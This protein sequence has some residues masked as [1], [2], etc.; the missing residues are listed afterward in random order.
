MQANNIIDSLA[1]WAKKTPNA[2]AFTFL[3]ANGTSQTLSYANLY[4]RSQKI[5]RQLKQ[6][7]QPNQAVLLCF[8][9][10]LQ[11]VET[12][13]A[14]LIAGVVAIPLYPPRANQKQARISAVLQ[15][16]GAQVILTDTAAH[17]A[18]AKSLADGAPQATILNLQP[19]ASDEQVVEKGAFSDIAFLQYT[20]GSTGAPKGVVVTHNNIVANLDALVEATGAN[21]KDVFVNWLPVFHDLGL[22]NTVLLPVYLGSHSVLMAP[23]QFIREP[24]FW[25]SA[26]DK[27]NG[28]IC[29]GPNFAFDHCVQ[30]LNQSQ[31]AQ[32]NLSSW[33]VAFNAAEPINA[34]T[35][36][37]FSNLC[38][39]ADFDKAAFFPSYGMAEATVFICG[40]FYQQ[41]SVRY[42][43]RQALN[44]GRAISIHIQSSE[45]LAHNTSALLSC[46]RTPSEHAIKI[47]DRESQTEC[48]EGH[49]G[50][51]WFNGP[52]VASGYWQNVQQSQQTF[53]NRLNNSDSQS[54]FLKTGDLGFVLN[55]E[56][57]IVGRCKDLII[58]NG[59]NIY[60]QDIE[61]LV[62]D[63]SDELER[64]S[65]AAFS[66]PQH[67]LQQDNL[68][69]NDLHQ[70]HSHLAVAVEVKRSRLRSF[71]DIAKVETVAKAIRARIAQEL[72]IT[73]EHV[74]FL[75]PGQL[76]KTSSGK[77]QR[78]ATAHLLQQSELNIYARSDLPKLMAQS[79][80]MTGISTN[81]ELS[82][83]Q[84]NLAGSGSTISL[85][86]KKI[87]MRLLSCTLDELDNLDI[88]FTALGG[89]SIKLMTLAAEIEREF[90]VHL[91]ESALYANLTLAQQ[92]LLIQ[93]SSENTH[94]QITAL[95]LQQGKLSA[96]QNRLWFLQQVVPDS[97]MLN[98]SVQLKF[99]G[100]FE[101]SAF[102]TA[103][104]ACLKRHP[105]LT[106]GFCQQGD[107]IVM[108]FAMYPEQDLQK[109]DLTGQ[110]ENQIARQLA[111]LKQ[112][113]ENCHFD[114]LSQ[115]V[116]Q[117]H[118]VNET[119]QQSHFFFCVHHIVADAWSFKIFLE[120][121]S[122]YYHR[123]RNAEVAELAQIDINYLDY[124]V[125]QEKQLSAEK[126]QNL[127]NFWQQTL[128]PMPATLALPFDYSPTKEKSYRGGKVSRTITGLHPQ[129]EAFAKSQNVTVF[130]AYCAVY[131]ILL[132]RISGQLDVVIGTDVIN[133][134][135]ASLQ[136]VF[137]F[138]VNQIALR[139]ELTLDDTMQEVVAKCQN[140]VS[141][142]QV[143]Q[144]LPFEQVVE[145]VDKAGD[146]S[147]SPVFQV[148]FLL[149]PSP[150]KALQLADV[151]IEQQAL[152]V[153]HAQYDLT[154]AVDFELDGSAQ[155]NCH[156]DGALFA[157]ST[158]GQLADSYLHILNQLLVHSDK[159]LSQVEYLTPNQQQ[160]LEQYSTG[161]KVEVTQ[162]F[163]DGLAHFA[164]ETPDKIACIT[165]HHQFSYAEINQR[166]NQLAHLL[167]AV[168]VQNSVVG[169]S[170]AQSDELLVALCAIGKIGATFVPLDPGYPPERLSFMLADSEA[171]FLLGDSET[172][173]VLADDFLGTML[174]LQEFS[175]LLSVQSGENPAV[176]IAAESLAYILY[177][178]GS[179]GQAKGVKV[180]YAA[181][182]NLCNW[183]LDFSKTT[184]DSV[185][186]Q[187]IPFGFDASIKNYFVPLMAGAQL[188]LVNQPSFDAECVLA[189]IKRYKVTTTNCIPSVFSALVSLAKSQ[190]YSALA[191]FQFVAFGGERLEFAHF[192]D[193][194]LSS[195]FNAS[196]ANI[197]GPTECTDIS[198][199][200]LLS[201]Q[202]AVSRAQDENQLAQAFPIG[203][204][205]QNCQLV[206]LTEQAE[207]QFSRTMPG[208]VGE[209]FITGRCLAEG[210]MQSLTNQGKFVQLPQASTLFYRTGDYA[211]WNQ[212]AELIYCG[213]ADE[214][215]KINGV[216][217]ELA[218][219]ESVLSEH[220]A[221]D[222]VCVL[223]KQ[224][225]LVAYVQS[226]ALNP[227][228]PEQCRNI[229][230]AKLPSVMVPHQVIFVDVF[231]T[232]PNG[233]IDRN[234]LAQIRVTEAKPNVDFVAPKTPVETILISCIE[235]VLKKQKVSM[236]DNFFELGGDS[237]LS[238]QLVAQLQNQG[239]QLAVKDIFD[240]PT[241]SELVLLVTQQAA[242]TD[243]AENTAFD[244]LS[245]DDLALL[246][247]E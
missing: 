11:F 118:L 89:D 236:S 201:A 23:A 205:I 40:R 158:V 52:S 215:V 172:L 209:I 92:L 8:A 64:L 189:L 113:Y 42:F 183:Y 245:E 116:Y 37:A 95:G 43:D 49:I 10:G 41:S 70:N 101:Q 186:L 48:A 98:I 114:L 230:K 132:S 14:C 66:L 93:T 175:E 67:N 72:E 196:I 62:I 188:V 99:S 243:A 180:S 139:T 131:Q 224:D 124:A 222:K 247:Q 182:N 100:D 157:P 184:A 232:L 125:W 211:K 152:P 4:D 204:P 21:T 60:P 71:K 87:W 181:L 5:A 109:I 119:E 83:T 19:P 107:E 123:I 25:L 122:D 13:Y 97:R 179:T 59:Q 15:S 20:S 187:L 238:V 129:L 134:E 50:E 241:F 190:D 174:N 216:R 24:L 3:L 1:N 105:V 2:N 18:V 73:I 68:H 27:F 217:I 185:A 38:K 22:I 88:P 7:I 226:A 145:L 171:S 162:H 197:Y 28:S 210:Y 16:S 233:K 51:I 121:L 91:D 234:K 150:L 110:D 6:H 225:R 153:Q 208:A 200:H 9:P 75:A 155:L 65:C 32:L 235:D 203:R 167:L 223:F 120:D 104:H 240:A 55:Q 178:S 198:A 30:K 86:L 103:W 214:Q 45:H 147:R 80:D 54:V 69:Q 74:L 160:I 170:L 193:W 165:E 159:C 128:S 63:C 135:N 117:A 12:F 115:P 77:V 206:L 177:T 26:I 46:G 138:F 164:D 44:Q 17:N 35:L 202:Q 195:A 156:F 151:K 81:I 108:R 82:E 154:F 220:P 191:S 39:P 212:Q 213:R 173:P 246:N 231:A 133:R 112:Q 228:T 56:L 141:A 78:A 144:F 136:Q 85:Q 96:A 199:A 163:T 29:G 166:A 111:E 58:V 161:Q 244:F 242:T 94:S 61:W 33:R 219:I 53:N 148:K 207:N 142:A 130:A 90:S 143:H 57:F 168:G 221:L 79:A 176:K 149:N 84:Q 237:I 102:T 218:E 169:I 126:Q 192:K 194:I 239:V 137:G 127:S 31:L 146:L 36:T 229:V 106:A 34:D 227:P 47:V 140:T 76:P